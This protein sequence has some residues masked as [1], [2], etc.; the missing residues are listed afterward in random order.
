M[1]ILP[2]N[3]MKRLNAFT[4]TWPL[5]PHISVAGLVQPAT[6]GSGVAKWYLATKVLSY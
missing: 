5:L 4:I 1:V 2:L 3:F 6:H